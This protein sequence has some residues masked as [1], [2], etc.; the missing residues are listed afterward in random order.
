MKTIGRHIDYILQHAERV[1]IPGIG[2]V[3]AHVERAGYM[4]ELSG[5]Q[6]PRRTF[7]FDPARVSG[8]A[9]IARSISRR[10]GVAQERA[11]Q[12]VAESVARMQASLREEGS[13]A[14]GHAGRL[15][16]LG[17]GTLSFRP[18]AEAWLSP[19]YMWLPDVAVPMISVKPDDEYETEEAGAERF[20]WSRALQRTGRV[21][22]CLLVALVAGWVVMNNLD[23]DRPENYASIVSTSPKTENL[24]P[25]PGASESTLVLVVNRH[26]DAYVPV[27]PEAAEAAP[28]GDYLLIVASLNS[29]AEA[30]K[31]IS[32]YPQLPLGIVNSDGRYRVYAADGASF[33]EAAAAKSRPEIA[34]VFESAWVYKK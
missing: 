26:E 2:C 32:R 5:W 7:T 20:D 25:M 21:A 22:A 17:D 11:E 33:A 16:V 24:L 18:S 15:S 13:V 14:L 29:Q 12:I 1:V 9:S 27:E 31:F 23:S 4:P 34:A 3:E 28:T 6:S 10:D 8:D 30:E 19:G